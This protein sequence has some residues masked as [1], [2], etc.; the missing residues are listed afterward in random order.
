MILRSIIRNG[1]GRQRVETP[2]PGAGL[3]QY[4]IDQL[5]FA[6]AHQFGFDE[7]IFFLEGVEHRFRRVDRHRRV[8]NEFAFFFGA[9]DERRLRLR[10]QVGAEGE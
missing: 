2:A 10:V 3:A 6:G 8:P 7:R 1:A 5:L 4:A 9:V